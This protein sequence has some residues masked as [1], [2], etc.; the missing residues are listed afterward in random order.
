MKYTDYQH[1]EKAF[2]FLT[3]FSVEQFR[4]LLVY[5]ECVH[6][7][8]FSLYDMDGKYHNHR[9]RFTIY[10]SSSLP[11]V[12]DC[13]FFIQVYLKNNLLQK[14]YAACFAMDQ[15]HCHRFIHVLHHVVVKCLE[16]TG[17]MPAESQ[18][19]LAVSLKKLADEAGEIPVLNH[20]E[21]GRELPRPV[22]TDEQQEN[23]SRK[24]K[25][26]TLK[27]AVING[28]TGLILFVSSTVCGKTH[29]KKIAD[30]MYSFPYKCIL[31]QDTRYQGFKPDGVTIVQ[32][33]RK[34]KGRKLSSQEKEFNRQVSS[35]RVQVEHAIRGQNE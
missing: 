16:D 12:E 28:A 21:T 10:K 7:K 34:A 19:K 29:D 1:N 27:N 4:E 8:Y 17:S 6:N 22:D 31:Y 23:Y 32:L 24:K 3:G 30:A 15:K 5:F 9:C 18:K 35:F 26:H 33:V 20:D 14:Y 2:R 25:K 11:S 13:L